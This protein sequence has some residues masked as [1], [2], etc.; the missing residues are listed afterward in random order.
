M[1]RDWL[2]K[3]A[4][5][6]VSD[7]AVLE[8]A[9][10]SLPYDDLVE[11]STDEEVVPKE[12]QLDVMQA[13]MAQAD[14]MGR[15]LARVHGDEL[16]KEA[17]LPLLAGLAGRAAGG[18]L[19]RRAVGG[20]IKDKAI[21]AVGSAVGSGVQKARQ[22]FQQPAAQQVAKFASEK[23]AFV[24]QIAGYAVGRHYGK[25][26]KERGE[27]HD[28][29][30]LQAASLLA[31][32]GIGY[33]IGRN[34]SHKEKKALMGS[35]ALKG[36]GAT[37]AS[38][39]GTLAR[40]AT[41]MMASDPRKALAIGGAALGAA[42]GL[43]RDPGF[44]EYGNRKSR[45]GAAAKGAIGGGA[46]GYGVGSLKPV[47]GALQ[48]AGK[49]MGGTLAAGA[50]KMSPQEV[51]HLTENMRSA[52]LP[53]AAAAAPA[54]EDRALFNMHG[55]PTAPPISRMPA[56]EIPPEVM[57]QL[58]TPGT[59]EGSG[60]MQPKPSRLRGF[61]EDMRRVPKN[62]G[63]GNATLPPSANWQQWQE[64][65]PAI[66]T[67]GIPKGLLRSNSPYAVSRRGAHELGRRNAPEF[68]KIMQGGDTPRNK[69]DKSLF[70]ARD[71]A[72]S[73]SRDRA[74]GLLE[75]KSNRQTLTIGPGGTLTRHHMTPSMASNNRVTGGTLADIGAGNIPAGHSEPVLSRAARPASG[76]MSMRPGAM[77][78][79]PGD[80][81]SSAA[82]PAPMARRPGTPPPIPAGARSPAGLGAS[83]AGKALPSLAGAKSIAGGGIPR[84][85]GFAKALS[86]VR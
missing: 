51:S 53:Q 22:G 76:P 63:F 47:Q 71:A 60:V 15:E 30:G 70:Q 11:L 74:R 8:D 55:G 44:D 28:F 14:Q 16:Q 25:K 78:Q 45:L 54:P 61:V 26:Q 27:K 4:E 84:A 73:R 81:V 50:K 83:S 72:A 23:T 82:R 42:Q 86:K 24:D 10:S 37:L 65:A 85:G 7:E 13:K 75:K 80:V 56:T 1:S 68:R 33:Q 12:D 48:N 35:A 3:M 58:G 17:F 36:L 34:V 18:G 43:V 38:K 62:L 21:G 66:K 46:L 67:A 59:G 57:A 79:A 19:L 32:G 52:P 5:Q 77:Q 39:G 40:G 29:G 9:L 2:V 69:F 41:N 6:A 49:S 31:P 64:A 20:I